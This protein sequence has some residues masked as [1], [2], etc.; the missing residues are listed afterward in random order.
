MMVGDCEP[1]LTLSETLLNIPQSMDLGEGSQFDS[2]E[3]R[4][5]I[6]DLSGVSERGLYTNELWKIKKQEW[7]DTCG[8]IFAELGWME[9]TFNLD[10]FF[11]YE[12]GMELT[13][14]YNCCEMSYNGRMVCFIDLSNIDDDGYDFDGKVATR[15]TTCHRIK[16][17]SYTTIGRF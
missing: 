3:R 10:S 1:L 16:S 2:F 12:N 15:H 8:L 17:K 4:R 5:L 7:E 13:V 11:E 14:P 6:E 9:D